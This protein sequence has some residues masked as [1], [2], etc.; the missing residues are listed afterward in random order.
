MVD[1]RKAEPPNL[2]FNQG[3]DETFQG[4][5][6][7]SLAWLA[8]LLGYGF[9]RGRSVLFQ[10]PLTCALPFPGICLGSKK[11]KTQVLRGTPT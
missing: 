7:V 6:H 8:G 11:V 5:Q 9:Q 4:R 3:E 10:S 1:R 2:V